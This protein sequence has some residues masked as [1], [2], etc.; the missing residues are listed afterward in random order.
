MN[1]TDRV[2]NF[3]K[4]DF[5][6]PS[7]MRNVYNTIAIIGQHKDTEAFNLLVQ[8]SQTNRNLGGV[9][10]D[11]PIIIS[12]VNNQWHEVWGDLVDNILNHAPGIISKIFH[13]SVGNTTMS[14]RAQ[15]LVWEAI[16]QHETNKNLKDQQMLL[17]ELALG[18]V[19]LNDCNLYDRCVE[20]WRIFDKI[21]CPV[22]NTWEMQMQ[23]AS[24]YAQ[25]W[26]F[27]RIAKYTSNTVP[28]LSYIESALP[29]GI[30]NDIEPTITKFAKLNNNPSFVINIIECVVR[31]EKLWTAENM[32]LVKNIYK[33]AQKLKNCLP[34]PLKVIAAAFHAHTHKNFSFE[35]VLELCD[36][37]WG[38]KM[39]GP[40][41]KTLAE[42]SLELNDFRVLQYLS[43]N[44]SDNYGL[45]FSNDTRIN[46]CKQWEMLLFQVDHATD[47]LISKTELQNEHL[48]A[49]RQKLRLSEAVDTPKHANKRKI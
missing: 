34:M 18:A 40:T 24:C 38:V 31:N 8:Y 11:S 47:V 6:S 28:L 37:A 27:E 7:G 39:Y 9:V 12:V 29:L 10:F 5:T 4:G 16:D 48:D 35:D 26:V 1:N 49:F 22:Q 21:H 15:E 25:N 43:A 45:A 13:L 41:L 42:K 19:Y 17:S 14:Q 2:E 44:H 33:E 36:L 20:R 46:S 32:S 3:C 30:A 23:V